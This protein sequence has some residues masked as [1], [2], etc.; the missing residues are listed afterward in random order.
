MTLCVHLLGYPEAVLAT[1]TITLDAPPDAT[2]GSVVRHVAA[3][4]PGLDEAL[5]HEDGS[6]RQTT[7][8]MVQD[9]PVDHRTPVSGKSA[10]TVLASLPCDG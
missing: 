8:V 10:V 1:D 5:L 6:P 3:L 2:A 7:K 4:A 9:V